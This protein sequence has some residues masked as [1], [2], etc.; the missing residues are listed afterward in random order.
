M[1]KNVRK[2]AKKSGFVFYSKNENPEM[3]I[4]W[5]SDYSKEFEV[6]SEKLLKQFAKNLNNKIGS[7]EK[8]AIKQEIRN[9]L[10]KD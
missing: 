7:K 10:L 2:I 1:N 4:D 9:F 5:S 3:P 8:A 6:F